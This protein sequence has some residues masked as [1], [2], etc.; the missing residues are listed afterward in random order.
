MIETIIECLPQR[1]FV[2][3]FDLVEEAIDPSNRLRLVVSSK[4][5]NLFWEA[6]FQGEEET[7]YLTALFASIDVVTEEEIFVLTTQNLFLL[8]LFVLVSHFFEHV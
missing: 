5:I 3:A 6:S 2:S 7:D 8:V 4:N 1:K